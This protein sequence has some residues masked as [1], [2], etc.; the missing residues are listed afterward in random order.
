VQ[1]DQASRTALLIAASLVLLHRDPKYSDLVSRGSAELCADALSGHSAQTRLFLKIVRQDWFRPIANL[2]ERLTIPGILLHYALRKKC[3]AKL[4]RSA[5]TGGATQVVI[6]GAGFD[7]LSFQLHQEFPGAQFWEIDHPATQHHKLRTFSKIR[8]DR[9]HF[10]AMDL[11]AA[12]INSEALLKSGFEPMQRAV[13]IVEGLLMYLTLDVVSSLMRTLKG[14]S[15]PGSRFVFTFMESE[16]TAGF[17][18]IRKVNWL[19]GGCMDVAN[20]S[21]GELREVNLLTSCIPG[22]LP[23]FSITM[24][25]ANWHLDLPPDVSPKAR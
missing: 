23:A 2:I 7:P 14:L 19:I 22:A 1:N 12:T 20:H 15:P 13:W 9:L 6:I 4:V 24:I 8:A 18:S 16:A 10:V 17:V 3:I 25:C 11:S 21:S 5:L